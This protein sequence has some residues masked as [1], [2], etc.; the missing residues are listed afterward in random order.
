MVDP[1]PNKELK[2]VIQYDLSE[3]KSI[4]VSARIIKK[5]D[6]VC[7]KIKSVFKRQN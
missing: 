7:C 1:T 2:F 4:D 5:D 6:A 3:I